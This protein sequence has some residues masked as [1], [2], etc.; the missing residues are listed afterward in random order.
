MHQLNSSVHFFVRFYLKCRKNCIQ[1]KRMDDELREIAETH[2]N[3]YRECS[4]ALLRVL[5]NAISAATESPSAAWGV[6]FAV[7]HPLCMGKSMS[8]VATKLR[9]PRAAISGIA[10][11]FCKENGLPPSSYMR[12]EEAQEIAKQARRSKLEH[13][14]GTNNSNS[15]QNQR[16]PSASL[17]GRQEISGCDKFDDASMRRNRSAC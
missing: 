7:S 2:P 8:D 12:S 16:T 13:E 5:H 6:M 14:S 9:V 3:I 15:K 4:R 17:G 11:R 10:T 1:I